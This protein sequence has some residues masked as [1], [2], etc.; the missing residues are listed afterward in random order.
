MNYPKRFS[1]GKMY[2]RE[3]GIYLK[4]KNCTSQSRYEQTQYE[5]DYTNQGVKLQDVELATFYLK[6]GLPYRGLKA[7]DNIPANYLLVQVPRQLIISSRTA[8]QSSQKAFY[9][10]HRDF[11]LDHEEGE[12]H[13]I[14]AFL[15]MN[16]R[17]GIKSKY[18]RFITQL[19][20]DV[21]MLI[22]WSEDKLK[23]LQDEN[24]IQKV[25]KKKEEYEQT[26]QIFKAIMNATE[27]EFQWAYSNLYTRDF[28]HNLKYKSM[29][30][31]CEFFNHECVDV[32]IA[33]L[34][35]DELKEQ[36]GQTLINIQNQKD[37][38]DQKDQ[39]GKKAT[40]KQ[41]KQQNKKKGD[42]YAE[43]ELQSVQSSSDSDN[44]LDLDQNESDLDDF[45]ADQ[46]IEWA[47]K[48]EL[49]EQTFE[50]LKDYVLSNLKAQYTQETVQIDR[51][52][53]KKIMNWIED[54]DFDYFC[55][56]SQKT[57]NFK[58][59]AQVYFNYGRL[60]NRELLLRYGI[61]I[62]RNKYD[63]VYLRI[64]TEEL[65]KRRG[66]RVF[67]KQYLSIKL[68]YTEFPFALLK[69]SKAITDFRSEN[70]DYY[71]LQNV[72]KTIDIQTELRGQE[73][74]IS[75]GLKKSI[76]LLKQFKGEFKEDLTKSDLLLK[77]KQLDYDE[78]FS[79][80]YRL[81]KQRILQQNI[82]L[83]Q[84]AREILLDPERLDYVCSSYE[85]S[86]YEYTYRIILKKYLEQI[87]IQ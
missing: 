32:H 52:E 87:L 45:I 3:K 31:F 6:N 33:L 18:Y 15:I 28:G 26:Y 37:Q 68:K 50:V 29:V 17:E 75:L 36:N 35:E 48:N 2:Q 64:N 59:G 71:D 54:E 62:E 7:T 22:F 4:D 23:L 21:N 60:S 46:I 8:F 63:H 34:S 19:P 14:M 41:T 43:E 55:I 70:Q 24:L 83:L 30:P 67:Q 38:K 85:S 73:F 56:S 5:I 44:S 81:E 20:I 27:N 57:E 82:I 53:T 12:E 58:K 84:L 86:Q 11:F 40:K 65:L 51:N 79:L 1:I 16:K 9:F 25:H 66:M 42:F 39:K 69:F 13:T 72:L 80:V 61:A 76:E 49:E 10:K 74:L 47:S 78:Y 77:D